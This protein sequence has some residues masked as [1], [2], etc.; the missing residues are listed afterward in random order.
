MRVGKLGYLRS[1]RG[2]N[3]QPLHWNSDDYH[4]VNSEVR[5]LSKAPFLAISCFSSFLFRACSLLFLNT[6]IDHYK[7][8]SMPACN[9]LAQAEQLYTDSLG[10]TVTSLSKY[11]RLSSLLGLVSSQLPRCT[12]N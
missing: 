11:Y 7:E 5:Q 1:L 3:P 9:E 2:V 8:H 4:T 10:E 6:C 12:P